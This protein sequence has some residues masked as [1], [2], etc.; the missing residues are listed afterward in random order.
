[1]PLCSQEPQAEKL[2]LGCLLTAGEGKQLIDAVIGTKFLSGF[3]VSDHQSALKPAPKREQENGFSLA[4]QLTREGGVVRT[5]IWGQ[6]GQVCISAP[7]LTIYVTLS[8]LTV[9][10]FHFFSSKWVL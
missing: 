6:A 4:D 1:M 10:A 8:V 5:W 7:L 3:W 2:P 9:F